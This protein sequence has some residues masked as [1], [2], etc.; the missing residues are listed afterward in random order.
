MTDDDRT[1]GDS[2]TPSSGNDWG[3][4][5]PEAGSGTPSGGSSGGTG[6]GGS[7]RCR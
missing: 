6:R 1:P 4:R 7:S 3:S 5:E 2:G